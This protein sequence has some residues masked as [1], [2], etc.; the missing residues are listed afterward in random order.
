MLPKVQVNILPASQAVATES[1][2]WIVASWVVPFWI[3]GFL[4]L[5]VR[6]L[7]HRWNLQRWLGD[8][9]LAQCHDL[10]GECK[11]MLSMKQ[12]PVLKMKNGLASPVVT[13]AWKPIIIL[14]VTF[15][16]WDRETQKMA[17]LHEL[18]H[19][20]RRDLWVRSAAE[21]ACILHWYNPLVWWLRA[22]SL[23][24]CE[25]ACD[26]LVIS[27]GANRQSYINALCDVV[28]ACIQEQ[29]PQGLV[30]MAD[31]APLQLRVNRLLGGASS[32]KPWLAIAVAVMTSATALGMTLIRPG[33]VKEAISFEG[34]IY[35]Q[36]E[37]DFRHSADPF[38]MD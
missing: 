38:P 4:V 5:G 18:G 10:L 14:P 26:A 3:I 35:S 1:S 6:F 21:L 23:S 16:E 11:V 13:G 20:Q 15:L 28:E 17:M 24:Q 9:D 22:Q 25:Y 33:A 30:A 27:S 7:L 29:R 12:S 2:F 34:P 32:G 8:T 36:E 31:H 37:I 19:I